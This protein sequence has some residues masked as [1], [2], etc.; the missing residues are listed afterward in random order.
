MEVGV[1]AGGQLRLLPHQRVHPEARLPVELHQRGGALGV[2]QPEGVDAEALHRA[3]RPRDAAVGHVPD[4]VVLRLGVQRDEVPERVVRALRLRDLQVGVRLAGVDDVRELD[5]VLD[6][7]HRDV[8]ADQ[9]ERPLVG[10]ELRRETPGVPDGVGGTA[11][12]QDGREAH[13]DRGLDVGLEEPRAGDRGGRAVGPERAVRGGAAG[14]HDPLGDALVVEVH[15]LLAQ[16]VVLQQRRTPPARLERVVGVAQ[17][18]TGRG[19][20]ER[21]GLRPALVGRPGG[22]TRGRDLLGAA[23]RRL[24]RQGLSRL[25]RLLERGGLGPGHPR[26]GRPRARDGLLRRR[27]DAPPRPGPPCSPGC[28]HQSP[29]FAFLPTGSPVGRPDPPYPV[30]VGACGTAGPVSRCG[31]S[32]RG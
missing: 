20:E 23:V 14:V 17:P 6:E 25:D 21:A 16:V 5:R 7:E 18:G 11:R 32:R 4:G 26:I 12:A 19:G 15:D 10:V 27:G 28:C 24:R 1:L 29:S 31:T 9:V 2:D 22:G 8:V 13:E 30:A 3:V